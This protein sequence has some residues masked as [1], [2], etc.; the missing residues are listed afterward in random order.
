MTMLAEYALAFLLV[1][2]S[3]FALV[4]SFGLLK[5]KDPM[6]RLHAPTKA[7]TLGVGAALAASMLQGLLSGG[8]PSW[9]EL[10][11]TI[12]L[13]LT[14]PLSALFLAKTHIHR[15]IDPAILPPTGT[16]RPWATL[17]EQ[18]GSSATKPDI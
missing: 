5:L 17:D 3:G 16:D 9:H 18:L 1:V 2:G 11:V 12:F 13:L 7:T 10:V 6:Q 8:S 4:G 15:T 14:A